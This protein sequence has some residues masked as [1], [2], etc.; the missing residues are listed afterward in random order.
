MT[1][2]AQRSPLF[3]IAVSR[4][5]RVLVKCIAAIVFLLSIFKESAGNV[6]LLASDRYVVYVTD[7]LF[8]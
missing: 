1:A 4:G 8:I 2:V 5:P 3:L 6:V 7:M